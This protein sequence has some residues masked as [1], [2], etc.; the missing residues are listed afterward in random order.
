MRGNIQTNFSLN[1][2][3]KWRGNLNIGAA[4]YYDSDA[5]YYANLSA[6][7]RFE[8]GVRLSIGSRYDTEDEFS[9]NLQL[10]IPLSRK[11]GKRKVDLDVLTESLD[12]SYETKLSVK[13][14]SLVGKNSIGGSLSH[15]QNNSTRQQNL[16]LSYRNSNFVSKLTARNKYSQSNDHYS[17]DLDIGFDTSIACVGVSCGTSYPISD[18]FALVSGPSN[19]KQPIAIS[20]KSNRFRY[21]DGNDT[22]LPDNYTA[23]IPKKGR[24]AVVSLDSYRYQNINIDEG[25]LP[26]GYDTEKTE[27][28]VFPS[29]HQGFLVKAGGEPATTI[30]GMLYNDQKKV[31]GFKGGQWIPENKGKTVAFFSNKAG[32][33]RVTS[34][35]AGKY[36]LELFDYPDMQPIHI[37]VPD[38][39]GKIH[40]VGDLIIKTP[41]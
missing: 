27:F 5:S 37:N 7:K 22:G 28:E 25:T 33:F 31:L 10:S 17:Q 13:P 38:T 39:K 3:E 8:N 15:Y 9:M 26:N 21:S 1:I 19:Q 23:L 30:D 34:I 32:R 16:N 18:S 35:P 11:R 41:N 24:K 4:D 36:K 6:T 20:S 14:T 29:Y 2:S 12:N 40:D